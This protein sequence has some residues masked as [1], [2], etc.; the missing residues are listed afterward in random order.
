MSDW[1][2][3]RLEQE[4]IDNVTKFAVAEKETGV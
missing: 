1:L 3:M 4:G 2:G